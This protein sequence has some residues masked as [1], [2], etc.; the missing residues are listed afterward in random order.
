MGKEGI[1]GEGVDGMDGMRAQKDTRP[2]P[3]PWFSLAEGKSAVWRVL[4]KN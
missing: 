3:H 1:R 2:T 4:K